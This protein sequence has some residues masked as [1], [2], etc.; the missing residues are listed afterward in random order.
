MNIPVPTLI[1]AGIIGSGF[2]EKLDPA[3]SQDI[4]KA[5]KV[6]RKFFKI[7]FIIYQWIIVIN[8]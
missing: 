3:G 5:A 6:K 4:M 8:K 1:S 7:D 2:G